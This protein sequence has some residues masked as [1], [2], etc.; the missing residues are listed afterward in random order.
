MKLK[1]FYVIALIIVSIFSVSG[2][3]IWQERNIYSSGGALRTGDLVIVQVNDV[4]KL[5]YTIQVEDENNSN[6]SSDPDV[7]IVAELPKIKAKKNI[8]NKERVKVDGKGDLQLTVAALVT[9]AAGNGNFNIQGSKE[10][11]VNGISNRFSV[12]GAINP[13]T[14]N[15]RTVL[16][17]DIVNFRLNIRGTKLGLGLQ[18]TR[19]AVKDDE[20][21][22]LALTEQEKQ[23]IILDYMQKMIQE[24]SR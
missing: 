24:L 23:R 2:R 12:S 10:Y 19:P 1:F 18:L 11:I 20:K 3:T 13:A 22:S 5:S 4:S 16:S 14:L 8:S 7:N 21:A 6:I 9:G 17:T 15:G